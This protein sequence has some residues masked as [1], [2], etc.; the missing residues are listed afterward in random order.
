VT[1]PE[2]LPTETAP[3]RKRGGRTTIVWIVL[4]LAGLLLLVTSFAVWVNRVALNT[5]VFS[6]TSSQ[7]LEDDAIRGAVATRA[8]DE[9]FT[10][11]DVQ[12]ELEAQ[13][14]EDWKSLS[15]VATAGARQGAYEVVDRALQQ[16]QLQSIWQATV[17]ETHRT[18]VQVLEGGGDRVSTDEG[19]VIL[20]MRAIVIEVA[21][22]IG[23]GEQVVDRIPADAGQIVV[24]RSDELDA[25]QSGFQLLKTLAWV[26]PLL[27]LGA[28]AL[29]VWLAPDRRR[30][31][32]GVGATVIVVGALGLVAAQFTGNYVVN[33]LAADRDTREASNNAWDILTSLMRSSFRWMIV[34]GLLFLVAAWLAGPGRRAVT[35]REFVAPIVRNRVWAYVGLAV[36]GL[37]L[38]LTGPVADFTRFLL[39]AVLVALGAVW[40]ELMRTQTVRE[41]PT[42]GTPALIESGRAR[43]SDWW[44]TR[45]AAAPQPSGP[46]ASGGDLTSRLAGLSELH[47]SGELTDDEYAA[48]K[49]RI[50]AGD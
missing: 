47:A 38:L 5:E 21:D 34:I 17:E 40:I 36:V 18:L 30:A 20:D 26:L 14:P 33:A 32:R 6:D 28:F 35:S 9:L 13:L 31:V 39:V 15:G 2:A 11:V 41:H 29:A 4:V 43:V 46:P 50:L 8:V 7:L 12:A 37:I 49:A 25:A 19:E 48:A 3:F 22:R 23:I 42:L 45:R 24:L 16:P 27:T 10:S 1:E 44:E